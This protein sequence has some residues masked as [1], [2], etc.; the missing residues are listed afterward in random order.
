TASNAAVSGACRPTTAEPMISARPVSS[1]WRVCRTTMK[2]LSS[3][4]S[5]A[6]EVNV[7][8]V[9]IEPRLGPA[10]GPLNARATTLAAVVVAYPARSASVG[11]RPITLL[12]EAA[13]SAGRPNVQISALVR[14]RRRASRVSRPV[15]VKTLIVCSFPSARSPGADR[16]GVGR[17]SRPRGA[18]V[19]QEQFLE[20]G[21][22]AGEVAYAEGGDMPQHR[23]QVPRL[24]LEAGTAAVDAHV[25]HARQLRQPDDRLVGLHDHLGAGQVT[26][27]GQGAG[28]HGA[29]VADDADPVAQRLHLGQHVAGE[30]HRASGVAQLADALAE[31][32]L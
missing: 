14:S 21:R 11:Y 30:Q 3:A 5:S 31:H 27:L 23:V 17:R 10:V 6:R 1:F 7:S 8:A 24:D 15:P 9:T 4:V 13:P 18:V 16:L 20:G 29:P 32:R 26:Q 22:G 19:P 28:L 25:V 2:V 12:A